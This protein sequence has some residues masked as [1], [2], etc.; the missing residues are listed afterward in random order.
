MSDL[1]GLENALILARAVWTLCLLLYVLT[2][3]FKKV[4]LV[5]EVGVILVEEFSNSRKQLA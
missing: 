3:F 2:S 4:D 5:S 1:S